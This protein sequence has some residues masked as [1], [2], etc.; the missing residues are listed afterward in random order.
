VFSS[1]QA[2]QMEQWKRLPVPDGIDEIGDEIGID[3]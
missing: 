2:M 3:A 1:T